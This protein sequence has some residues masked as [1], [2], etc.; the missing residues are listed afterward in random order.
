MV[1]IMYSADTGWMSASTSATITTGGEPAAGRLW[2]VADWLANT[3]SDAERA[4]RELEA[5]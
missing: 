3:H 4:S 1:L 2:E 5:R